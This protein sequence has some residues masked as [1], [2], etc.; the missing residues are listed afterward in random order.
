M[1]TQML[2]LTGLKSVLT[3]QIKVEL[4]FVFPFNL[5]WLLLTFH[6][7]VILHAGCTESISHM[8]L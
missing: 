4:M 6:W 3:D 5:L 8:I 1:S 2:Y 7:R